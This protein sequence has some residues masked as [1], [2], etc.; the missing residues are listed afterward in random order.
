MGSHRYCL[1][2]K[3]I[4][5]YRLDHSDAQSHMFHFLQATKQE[6]KPESTTVS[7]N[8][9]KAGI[10][11]LTND[12]FYDGW[13]VFFFTAVMFSL[14]L[15]NLGKMHAPNSFALFLVNSLET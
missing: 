7:I 3:I 12:V 4:H 6:V 10:D 1:V 14:L 8:T 2:Q 11:L 9:I 5:L 13:Y 15:N